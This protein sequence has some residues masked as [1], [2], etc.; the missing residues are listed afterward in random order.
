VTATCTDIRDFTC[1]DMA[2]MVRDDHF[3]W[4]PERRARE[5]LGA[6]TRLNLLALEYGYKYRLDIRARNGLSRIEFVTTLSE[7][8]FIG[9]P[10]RKTGGAVDFYKINNDGTLKRHQW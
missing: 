1:F 8:R 9:R 10:I 6:D 2:L 5:A 3:R 7:A 4:L